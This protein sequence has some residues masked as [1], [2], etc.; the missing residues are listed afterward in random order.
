[1]SYPKLETNQKVSCLAANAVQKTTIASSH[2][3]K[4]YPHITWAKL[5]KYS[6][7]PLHVLVFH[8]SWIIAHKPGDETLTVAYAKSIIPTESTTNPNSAK[9]LIELS[10]C[11][12]IIQCSSNAKKHLTLVVRHE[13]NLTPGFFLACATLLFKKSVHRQ[14]SPIWSFW[15]FNRVSEVPGFFWGNLLGLKS[16]CKN[17]VSSP[18]STAIRWD[19]WPVCAEVRPFYRIAHPKLW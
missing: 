3:S 17:L 19:R 18:L 9:I 1:M 11:W 16:S 12:N 15:S 10:R 5:A 14:L 13:R 4:F 8:C 2:K 7:R 6:L